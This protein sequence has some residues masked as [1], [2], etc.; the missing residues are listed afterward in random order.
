MHMPL[1][2][3]TTAAFLIGLAIAQ[4]PAMSQ[5]LDTRT[6]QFTA[7][8]R[9]NQYTPG[10][11]SP[12]EMYINS[13]DNHTYECVALNGVNTWENFV[14]IS[15]PRGTTASLPATCTVG[16][17]F[18]ATDATSSEQL[19][20]CTATNTWTQQTGGGG[21]SVI[22]CASTP[23]PGN[24]TGT[25][26]QQCQDGD[27]A[28]FACNNSGG[29]T[30]SG[31]WVAVGGSGSGT[32]TVVGAGNLT[33]G[34]LMTGGGSQTA[35]TACTG[36]TLTSGGLMT[37]P[38]SSSG[39]AIIGAS[40]TG[41]LLDL[42]GTNATVSTGGALSL[43][44]QLTSTVT[45]G[46]APFVV[47]STTQVANLNAA[48]LGG[49]TFAAP[50]AIGGGTPGTGAFTTLSSTGLNS[51]SVAS[52]QTLTIASGGTLT[53]A[54]G[55]TCPASPPYNEGAIYAIDGGGAT[56]SPTVVLTNG[57]NQTL[58]L[59]GNT[60]VAF[61]QP[62]GYVGRVTLYFKQAAGAG[63]T[64]T[65]TSVKWPGGIAPVMTATASAIDIYSCRLD[66][67]FTYCTA[68]QAF[69]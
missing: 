69:Q 34:A 3:P 26:R 6:Y 47:A 49:A 32:V 16:D 4:I 14:R 1:K 13:T 35:Q 43:A 44:G 38:G 68:G 30:T 9:V 61:T 46:T 65:W 37:L 15:F 36:C 29:C 57:A 56:T 25:Y 18:I 54:A 10:T 66:G 48:A 59:S 17:P 62:S 2:T 40:A 55:S 19:Y 11:C 58:T 50:G 63:D 60:T 64:V 21:T 28:I 52:G 23:G 7:P 31:D 22:A 67:T 5:S 39:S 20:I 51:T 27:G 41:S 12:W 24:T 33:S 53:C 8:I 45:T 42:N